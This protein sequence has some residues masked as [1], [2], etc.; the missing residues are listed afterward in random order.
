[1]TF[2]T[3]IQ[4]TETYQVHKVLEPL[5]MPKTWPYNMDPRAPHTESKTKQ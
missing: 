3:P 1:L 2:N 4:H 5:T